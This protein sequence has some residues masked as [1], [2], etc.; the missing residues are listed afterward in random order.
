MRMQTRLEI[1]RGDLIAFITK[2]KGVNPPIDAHITLAVDG[3]VSSEEVTADNPLIVE[4][5]ERL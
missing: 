3:G 4:W 1:T 5:E 2:D